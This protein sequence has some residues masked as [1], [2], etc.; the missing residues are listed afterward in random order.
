MDE[1]EF[2]DLFFHLRT[3]AETEGLYDIEMSFVDQIDM[4][5]GYRTAVLEYLDALG[6]ALRVRS[7]DVKEKSL[8]LINENIISPGSNEIIGISLVA[9]SGDDQRLGFSERELEGEPWAMQFADEIEMLRN[10]LAQTPYQTP[11]PSVS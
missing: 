9:T 4:N 10:E 3:R 11:G 6:Q 8:E 5:R 2:R 1:N 7:F